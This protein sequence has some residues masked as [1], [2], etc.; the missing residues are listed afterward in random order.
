[1][2]HPHA[3]WQ[4]QQAGRWLMHSQPSPHSQCPKRPALS[5]GRHTGVWGEGQNRCKK[6]RMVW[7][8]G[9]FKRTKQPVLAYLMSTLGV[10]ALD[11]QHWHKC[12]P[13]PL[14]LAEIKILLPHS[15]PVFNKD[16]IIFQGFQIP[17]RIPSLKPISHFLGRGKHAKGNRTWNPSSH[18]Q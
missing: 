10:L 11:K 16:P 15:T 8:W 17:P 2:T 12:P 13:T 5:T 4:G 18:I 1:M 3:L 9:Q 14:F 6:P 7:V